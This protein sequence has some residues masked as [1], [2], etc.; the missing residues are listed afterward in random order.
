LHLEEKYDRCKIIIYELTNQILSKAKTN[1]HPLETYY[2]LLLSKIIPDANR[3]IYLDGDTLVF[4][5]L[6]EMFN[7]E[8]NNNIILGFVD[9][10]L[11]RAEK[12]GIKT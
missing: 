8:M 2:R 7:L 10:N 1:A 6:T 3:V 9:G 5:D 11:K 12:F 4:H